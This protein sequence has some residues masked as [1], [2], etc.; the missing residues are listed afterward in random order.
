MTLTTA[1]AAVVPL[2]GG[3]VLYGSLAVLALG[4]RLLV[5]TGRGSGA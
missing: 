5:G 1:G 4:G 2:P 3:L